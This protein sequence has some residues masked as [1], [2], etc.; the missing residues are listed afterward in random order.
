MAIYTVG[1]R[2]VIIGLLLSAALLLTLDLR[3]N[4]ALDIVRD[5]FSR[6]MVPVER[7]TDVVV[8]PVQRGW[9]SYIDYDDLERE[10][11]ALRELLDRDAGTRATAEASIIDYQLLLALNDLPSLSGIDTAKAQVV[12]GASNNIDQIV[13]INKGSNDGIAEGMPVVNQAGLIGKVTQVNAQT[14]KVM[15]ITDPRFSIA[16][17]ILSGTGLKD[18]GDGE[19]P[20]GTTPSGLSEDEID[21]VEQDSIDAAKGAEADESQ[22]LTPVDVFEN[23]VDL[24]QAGDLDGLPVDT[25]TTT[26]L[27]EA[28]PVGEE[29]PITRDVDGLQIV[30]VDPTATTTIIGLEP[31][32]FAKEFGVLEGRGQGRPSQ[33]R[34]VQDVPSLAVL[35]VGDLVETAGGS[36]SLAPPNIPVGRVINRADRPG[37][38][39]PLLEVELIADLDKLNFVRVVLFRPLSEINE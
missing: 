1:R 18:D 10:N 39:G 26:T 25:D 2:R 13:E 7:A 38:A 28:I 22:V 35:E 5:G 21:Q 17:E 33:I 9:N 11:E 27:P 3:G 20:V 30:V 6:S 12:G 36:A 29:A 4:F 19:S 34:F 8:R 14:S 37:V 32:Q 31:E 24:P 23:D 15:L 16:V